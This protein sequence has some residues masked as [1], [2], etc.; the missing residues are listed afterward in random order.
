MMA[1]N[2]PMPVTMKELGIDRLEPQDR[3]ALVEEIWDSLTADLEKL[4]LAEAQKQ[5]VDSRLAA[6]RLNPTA[7]IPW[8]QVEAEALA[9]LRK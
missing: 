7:A 4:P 8:E 6:H 1:W 5:E 9:R 3:L 2:F